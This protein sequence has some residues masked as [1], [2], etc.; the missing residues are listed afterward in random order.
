L[1]YLPRIN[2][3]NNVDANVNLVSSDISLLNNCNTSIY[4]NVVNCYSINLLE[5]KNTKTIGLSLELSFDQ[6]KNIIKNYKKMFNTKPN[7]EVMVYGRYELMMMKY[8]AINNT[9]GCSVCHQGNVKI[10]DRKGFEFPLLKE[11]DCT[12]KILNTKKLHLKSYLEEI[13]ACGVNNV[14]IYFTNETYQE[15]IDV[16]DIYFNNSTKQIEDV[17]FG[18]FK[19]GVL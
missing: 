5:S 18:H 11:R 16:C 10:K 17:T 7:L 9:V 19:E 3:K 14:L 12:M 1:Y 13:Y 2:K 15:V 6:I 8:C 4:M